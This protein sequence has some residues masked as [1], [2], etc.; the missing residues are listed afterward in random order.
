M[1]L[2][3]QEP[4]PTAATAKAPSATVVTPQND[5]S[6]TAENTA[7][8][9]PDAPSYVQEDPLSESQT[10]EVNAPALIAPK[11][12]VTRP[13][14]HKVAPCKAS[15][16]NCIPSTTQFI[17]NSRSPLPILS[18]LQKLN[19]AAHD[20]IDPFN[21]ASIAASSAIAVAADSH[22]QY[23]PGLEGFGK[24]AG[25]GL[26][27]SLT[28]E[29][30]GTFAIP[31]IAHQDPRYH[32]MPQASFKR[33][34]WHA[35]SRTAISQS[36]HGRP[37]PNY[38]TL[39]TYPIVNEMANAYVPNIQ[40]DAKSTGTRIAIGYATDPISNIIAEFLP[41]IARRIHV[42]SVFFQQVLTKMA[43]DPAMVGTTPGN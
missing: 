35:I 36:D 23:G 40:R 18:P 21:L 37:M 39:L 11:P 2:Y 24:S 38:G 5:R 32:R 1:S 15:D 10:I 34:L 4:A 8:N 13:A 30:F 31:A 33:R 41:D 19:L 9:L 3:A 42:R 6:S 16:P 43:T 22:N 14:H 25:V 17:L 28:G 29:F 26:T 7:K 27:G 20:F 12:G